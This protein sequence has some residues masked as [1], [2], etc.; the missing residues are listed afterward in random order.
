MPSR[1]GAA[2]VGPTD[3]N[4]VRDAVEVDATLQGIILARGA[5]VHA[6]AVGAHRQE[7]VRASQSRLSWTHD[8]SREGMILGRR[9]L[10]VELLGQ[11]EVAATAA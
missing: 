4:L 11:A 9:R 10:R 3:Q 2:A 6:V 8:Q 1:S 7:I 5:V